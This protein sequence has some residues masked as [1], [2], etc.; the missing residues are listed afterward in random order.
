[1]NFTIKPNIQTHDFLQ[2][3][4]LEG[5][6]LRDFIFAGNATFTILN[7]S[8]KN[9]FTYKIKYN[10][11]R[12][13]FY[14]SVM[15]GTSNTRS[16]TYLG[17]YFPFNGI[18]RRSNYSDISRQDT[19]AKALVWF[20]SRYINYQNKYPSIKVFHEDKCGRCGRK[21]TTPESVK[22]GFGPECTKL[23]GIKKGK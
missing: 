6:Q 21:L 1:M 19:S 7:E 16:F 5:K 23:M 14:I 18:Y 10:E 2:K 12:K 3:H 13:V 20:F 22:S 9:R 17:T 11:N 4:L 8:T 15:T